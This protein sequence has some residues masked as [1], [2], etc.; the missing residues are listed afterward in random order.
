MNIFFQRIGY[1]SGKIGRTNIELRL[2]V[3]YTTIKVCK[4][5]VICTNL[6]KFTNAHFFPGACQK[7]TA[8]IPDMSLKTKHLKLPFLIAYINDKN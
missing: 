5:G 6:L 2:N 7:T 3:N 1:P 8:L 4:V